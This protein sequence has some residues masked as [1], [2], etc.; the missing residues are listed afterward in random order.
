MIIHYLN[1]VPET[2]S[3]SWYTAEPLESWHLEKIECLDEV[4]YWYAYGSYSGVGHLIGRVGEQWTHFDMSHCSC[5]GP[6]D[7][8]ALQ[9]E[10]WKQLIGRMSLDLKNEVEC[11]IHAIQEST[12]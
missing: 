12:K 1:I 2:H 11:L 6:T 3:S 9:L 4:W 10:P 5:Y 7:Q 8:F